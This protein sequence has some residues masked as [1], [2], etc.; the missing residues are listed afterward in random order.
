MEDVALPILGAGGQGTPERVL[1]F[2]AISLT[3]K[4]WATTGNTSLGLL[5]HPA[6]IC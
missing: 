6:C 2:L 5:A 1:T 4:A 3:K